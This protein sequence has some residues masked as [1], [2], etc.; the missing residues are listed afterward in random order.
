[1]T[2][3]P[4]ALDLARS[5]G[6]CL[7]ACFHLQELGTHSLVA[8]PGVS[9]ISVQLIR[10]SVRGAVGRQVPLG[11]RQHAWSVPRPLHSPFLQGAEGDRFFS[12][13]FHCSSCTSVDSVSFLKSGVRDVLTVFAGQRQG[14]LMQPQLWA[15]VRSFQERQT[16]FSFLTCY[17]YFRFV[18]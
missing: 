10:T 4:H 18:L 3:Y 15:F 8:C 17:V 6:D 13:H 2:T 5:L 7:S 12:F 14:S 1:M 11:R 16:P 9:C